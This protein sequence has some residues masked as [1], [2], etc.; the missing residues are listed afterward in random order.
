MAIEAVFSFM[1][2]N[3]P[4]IMIAGGILLYLVGS[5]QQAIFGG[6]DLLGPA[7]WIIVGGFVLQVLW[8]FFH[9]GM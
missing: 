6:S 4:S 9:H 5:A 8:L 7:P 3:P 2:R 1:A